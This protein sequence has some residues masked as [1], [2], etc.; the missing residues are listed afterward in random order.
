[1]KITNEIKEK[2]CEMF[3]D[4]TTKGAIAR[5]LGIS[6]TSV[7][8]ILAEVEP[9]NDSNSSENVASAKAENLQQKPENNSKFAESDKTPEAAA[10]SII[11]CKECGTENPIKNLLNYND[12]AW[13]DQPL[14]FYNEENPFCPECK[15]EID[16]DADEEES[17]D[18]LDD[19]FLV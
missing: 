7:N 15:E 19:W 17:K 1:M 10:E 18:D 11:K 16:L 13:Y 8:N 4:G 9:E 3:E 12:L 2:T 5:E 14:F 6:R